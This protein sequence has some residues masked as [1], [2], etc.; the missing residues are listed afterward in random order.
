MATTTKNR[1]A[2][3]TRPKAQAPA[4]KGAAKP[5][6]PATATAVKATAA[7]ATSTKSAAKGAAVK[8]TPTKSTPKPTAAKAIAT[9]GRKA[10]KAAGQPK[11]T[12]VKSAR[13]ASAKPK[14]GSRAAAASNGESTVAVNA[15]IEGLL[16][17]GRSEGFITQDQILEVVPQPEVHLDKI[18]ELFAVAE[19]SGVEVLDA[20]NQPTLIAEPDEEVATAAGEKKPEPEEDLE[21]LAADLIGIDDPVRMY[22]KEIGKVA[23]L[24]AEEEVVLAKAIELGEKAVE[25]P[26]RAMVDLYTWVSTNSEPKARSMAAMRAFD[27]PKDAPHV[28]V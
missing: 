2:A 3:A 13:A 21:A 24:T 5:A 25:D 14:K 19:E 10:T 18:E 22:L 20:D 26:G 6:G 28:T 9:N 12:P 16:E 15:A 7:K 11:A 4:A 8:A 17:K 27:L 23:L 1:E